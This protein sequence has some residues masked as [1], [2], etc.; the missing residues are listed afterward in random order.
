MLKMADSKAAGEKQPEAD[1]LG[2][3][4]DCFDPRTQLAYHFQ[5]HVT[6][7]ACGAA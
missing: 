1:P 7:S 3:I 2:Y 6:V 4:E 5:H